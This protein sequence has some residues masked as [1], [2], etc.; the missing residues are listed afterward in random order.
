MILIVITGI[1]YIVL[2]NF[3]PLD[4]L[5]IEQSE[6]L[7][8]NFDQFEKQ[9]TYFPTITSDSS[10]SDIENKN[11]KTKKKKEK[12]SKLEEGQ[13][14]DLNAASIT[15]LTRIPSIGETFA[16]R[17]IEYRNSLGGFASLDQL[18]EIKGISMNKFSK[19]LPYIVIQ[20]KHKK[21]NLNKDNINHPYIN[22]E[23][24]SDLITYRK[25]HTLHSVDDLLEIASFSNKDIE[26]LTPYISFK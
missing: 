9:L 17:I 11:E 13:T 3:T 6:E 2:H 10:S 8:D 22:D 23:Q 14:I 12:L 1:F 7:E 21:I 19:I 20:K 25:E 5:Y 26:R 4:P 24:L 15:T 16:T 18:R